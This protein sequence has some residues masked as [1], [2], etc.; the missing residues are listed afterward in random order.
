MEICL[1][2]TKLIIWILSGCQDLRQSGQP[3][4]S[5]H[6]FTVTSG[7]DAILVTQGNWEH[8]D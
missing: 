5:N 1:T 2:K 6:I 3:I 4:A 8:T 7:S